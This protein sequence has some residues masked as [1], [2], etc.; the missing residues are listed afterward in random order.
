MVKADYDSEAEALSIVL[1]DIRRLDDQEQVDEDYCYVGIAG[2]QAVNVS[3]IYPA[4][5]L[6]LLKDAAERYDLD[7]EALVAI[8]KAALAAPDRL[9]TMDL[10]GVLVA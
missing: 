10:S 3:L 6:D 5:H 1:R 8:A 7:G 4:Q 2:G 9:V